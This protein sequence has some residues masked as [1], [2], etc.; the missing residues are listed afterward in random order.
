MAAVDP[1][2][3]FAE[4]AR[5]RH[6]GVTVKRAPAEQLPFGNQAF[7]AAL[8]ELVV[9]FMEDPVA[10][11]REMARVT[12]QDGVVAACVWDHGVGG[13]G[14]LSLFWDAARKLDPEV[15]DESERAG[16]RQGH[17]AELFQKAGLQAIEEG[18]LLIDLEHRSFEDWWE[19]FTLGVGPAGEFVVGLDPERRSR[20]Q[21][22][23]SEMLPP[24]PF[25]LTVRAWAARGFV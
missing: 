20:L 3:P 7:D 1:S 8:A 19:P 21:D 14:P 10:G 2:E 16:T 6:P 13:H 5:V 24:A 22:L 4:A 18:A 11:L 12:R 23:C 15:V 9:H 25:V 17:L